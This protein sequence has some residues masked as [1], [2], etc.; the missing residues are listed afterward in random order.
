M[1]LANGEVSCWYCP[2]CGTRKTQEGT[3]MTQGEPDVR[4]D[5]LSDGRVAAR[6]DA[7]P[8]EPH[9]GRSGDEVPDGGPAGPALV[10]DYQP[11]CWK[12]GRVL[13]RYFSRPW[14][15]RCRR[16]KATNQDALKGT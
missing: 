3:V 15:I 12:C 11:R 8:D 2:I 5:S 14:S 10:T 13:G 16:C 7:R 9:T 1:L 4:A 6:G